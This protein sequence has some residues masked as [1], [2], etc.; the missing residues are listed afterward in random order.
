MMYYVS[1]CEKSH[2]R[3]SEFKS[4][5]IASPRPLFSFGIVPI[6]IV[7]LYNTLPEGSSK[8]EKIYNQYKAP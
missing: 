1:Y 7:P 5:T 3:I 4:E 2:A 8:K 6:G